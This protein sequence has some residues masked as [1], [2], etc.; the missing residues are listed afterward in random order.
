MCKSLGLN[1]PNG[2]INIT[3]I[4]GLV[5]SLKFCLEF[6]IN[7]IPGRFTKLCIFNVSD[8]NY[9]SNLGRTLSI[10]AVTRK[11]VNYT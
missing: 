3:V 9:T 4:M 6:A 11:M 8:V 2:V 1:K 5:F 7:S 10:Y